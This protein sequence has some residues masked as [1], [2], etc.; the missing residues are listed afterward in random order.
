MW[1]PPLAIALAALFLAGPAYGLSPAWGGSL[2]AVAAIG[3][4]WSFAV[5]VLPRLKRK[6]AYSLDELRRVQEEEE[7]RALDPEMAL[8]EPDR[9]VCAR[10]M[11]EYPFR[12][13]AC[14]RCGLSA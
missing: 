10:C 14:P 3:A 12:L 11:N 4:V 7:L 5:G 8:G 6:D 1:V 13:G 9:V 2:I